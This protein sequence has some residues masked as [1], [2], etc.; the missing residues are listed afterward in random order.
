MR[1]DLAGSGLPAWTTDGKRELLPESLTAATDGGVFFLHGGD[2]YRKALAAKALLERYAEPATEAFNVDRIV[3]TE[4]TV[5]RL[6]SIIATPPMMASWR[7]VH[8][9]ET[10]GLAAS[11][12]A[13]EVVLDAAKT[14]PPGLV[15]ILQ[16]TVPARSKAR[17]YKDLARMATAVEFKPVPAD[18]VPGWLV[19]WARDELGVTVE[20]EAAQALAAAAG[21][22]LG[23]LTQE[24]AK[25]AEMVGESA[26][27]DL[28][29][30]KKGGIRLPVQD[31]WAWFDLVGNR[32]IDEAARGLP[33]LIEQGESVIGLVIG[34]STQLLRIGVAIEGGVPALQAALPPY[35]RFLAR[36]IVAQ[37]RRWTRAE[38]AGAVRGLRRLDQLLKASAISGEVLMEEWLLGLRVRGRGVRR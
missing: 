13:R 28:D 7:V 9:K 37:A 3:G 32:R 8:V 25:L 24:V 16:A 26:V 17:F 10:E 14:P 29:A 11:P 34:L 35:Q 36:R 5:E 15:L 1:P 31:R 18:A 22:E 23:M 30:V 4:T 19:T 38:L 20:I 6:A 12:K 2:E 33:V 21:T 27:V